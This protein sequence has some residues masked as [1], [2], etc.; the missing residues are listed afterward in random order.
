MKTF[1][2]KK[3]AK[4]LSKPGVPLDELHGFEEDGA[5]IMA[6]QMSGDKQSIMPVDQPT[7]VD[8]SIEQQLMAANR[9]I[10]EQKIEI[11][12]LN[13]D[14]ESFSYSVSHDLR[15]PL[16][17]I[18]GYA[19]ILLED[20]PDKLDEEGNRMLEALIYNSIK[21][22]NLIDDLLT[23]SRLGKKETSKEAINMNELTEGVLMDIQKNVNHT[24]KINILPLPSTHADYSQLHHVMYQLISNAIKFSSKKNEPEIEIGAQFQ[25][26]EPVFYVKDNGDGFDMKYYD[27]LFLVFQRLH[28]ANEFDGIGIGLAIVK[29]IMDKHKG[30]VWADAKKG[31]G[32]TF[33][34]SLPPVAI[35]DIKTHK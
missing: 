23:F 10:H 28:A 15:S 6:E 5:V 31:V 4:K 11:E 35:N 34:F 25:D 29:R 32:A 21:M 12:R 17:A 13:K 19:K 26:Q 33:F 27:K 24:A 1:D 7:A 16:R 18:T 8:F 14:L 22:G 20:Y 30:K 9:V 2:K 3:S